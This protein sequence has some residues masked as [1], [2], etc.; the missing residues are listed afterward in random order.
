M[1]ADIR[2]GSITFN[3]SPPVAGEPFSCYAQCLNLG[4]EGT[5][6]FIARFQLDAGQTQDVTVDNI[7]PGETLYATCPYA[8]LAA[9]D[10]SVFCLLDAGHSVAEPEERFNQQTQYFKVGARSL[11]PSDSD[12]STSYDDNALA[13]AVAN[14]MRDR[15]DHWMTLVVQAVEEWESETRQ[16][17][18][19]WD[20]NGDAQVDFMS[21]LW[22]FA[23]AVGSRAP[24]ASTALGIV[25][26]A[27][28]IYNAI[29]AYRGTS[30][31]RRRRRESQAEGIGARAQDG[32]GEFIAQGHRRFRG[33][34]QCV[35]EPEQ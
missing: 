19:Q 31:A 13:Q 18:D 10:H 16:R 8:A 9:G 21:V 26:D 3:P 34:P 5:G 28:D 25:K 33:S 30:A 12:G 2:L 35:V 7:P 23:S 22:A 14:E 20:F 29:Q 6:S 32:C 4:D 27:T 17:I 11:P 24:G 15:V 1:P